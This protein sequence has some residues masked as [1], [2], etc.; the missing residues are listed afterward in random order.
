MLRFNAIM[1]N[2]WNKIVLFCKAAGKKK[3]KKE[4]QDITGNRKERRTKS[5]G[6]KSRRSSSRKP[7]VST[8]NNK[9]FSLGEPR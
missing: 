7:E 5:V 2:L 4:N 9:P 3:A 6:E 8:Q 1:C